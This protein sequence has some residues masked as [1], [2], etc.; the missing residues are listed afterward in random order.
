MAKKFRSRDGSTVRLAMTSGHVALVGK[1]FRE[2]PQ[3]YWSDAYAKG[4][5]SDDMSA[6]AQGSDT[7]NSEAATRKAAI[8]QAIEKMHS[9]KKDGDFTTQ[10]VPQV[11]R[12]SELVGFTITAAER[13]AVWEDM[14]DNVD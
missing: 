14:I 4:C 11:S 7:G 5:I 10:G 8:T 2:L 6:E 1:E 3:M 13:D 12:I 9:E